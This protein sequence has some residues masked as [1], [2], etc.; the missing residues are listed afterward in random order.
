M[1]GLGDGVVGVAGERRGGG[2]VE[3]VE[4]VEGVWRGEEAG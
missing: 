4:G 1:V 2:V 3:I